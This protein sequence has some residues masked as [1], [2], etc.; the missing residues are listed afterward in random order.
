M[1]V[2]E[3]DL[4]GRRVLDAGCGTGRFVAA[5]AREAK[6]WG[7]DAS[8]EMLAVARTRVPSGVRLK[9]ARAEEPPFRNGWFD[10]V[11]YWLVIHLLDR[12]AAFGAARRLLGDG[13]RCCIVTFDEAH[14]ESYWGNR[15]FPRLEELDRALF[16]TA[17]DLKRE[18]RGAGFSSLR[19][20]RRVS[21]DRIDRETALA[22][23]RGKHISTY[24]RLEPEE[25]EL[26]LRRAEAELP[27]EVETSLHWLLAFAETSD[28]GSSRV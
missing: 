12:P 23:I 10:R 26:G 2:R 25:F 8:S 5:L 4:R 15:F 24:D 13:G 18:L 20:L 1:L 7:I 21:R 16:P 6:V 28:V 11:V 14:F 27:A 19:M 9:Q 17:A 3:G 22:K